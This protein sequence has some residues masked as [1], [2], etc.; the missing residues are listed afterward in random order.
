MPILG[1]A[2][3]ALR[4]FLLRIN[5][6]ICINSKANL[7]ANNWNLN[8]VLSGHFTGYT[9][10]ICLYYFCPNSERFQIFKK[11]Q[12]CTQS[13]RPFLSKSLC[14]RLAQYRQRGVVGPPKLYCITKNCSSMLINTVSLI[15]VMIQIIAK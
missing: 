1:P 11:N 8:Q 3:N 13:R 6:S 7:K 2:Y 10:S 4:I 15:S 5:P 14:Q 9:A 12:R